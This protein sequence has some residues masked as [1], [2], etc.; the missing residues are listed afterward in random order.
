[1]G[2]KGDIARF[3]ENVVS[4]LD[5]EIGLCMA[6]DRYL[7][8]W[9]SSLSATRLSNATVGTNLPSFEPPVTQDF[10]VTP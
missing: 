9:K 3:P 8:D 6:E 4:V 7:S 2:H 1:V 5:T 10:P